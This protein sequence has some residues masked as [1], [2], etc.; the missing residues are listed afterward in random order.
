VEDFQRPGQGNRSWTI[1]DPDGTLAGRITLP[2]RFNPTEIGVDYILGL[3]WDEMNVEYVR[4][5]GLTRGD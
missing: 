1:F 4:M 5:Y 2:E 3:G